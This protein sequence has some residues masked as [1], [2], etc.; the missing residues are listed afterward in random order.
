MAGAGH[1]MDI[2]DPS[3]PNSAGTGAINS[4]LP[5][6]RICGI[7]YFP[8]ATSARGLGTYCQVKLIFNYSHVSS[9]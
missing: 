9:P 4:A 5:L 3:F 1:I 6:I 2:S 8:F 7:S